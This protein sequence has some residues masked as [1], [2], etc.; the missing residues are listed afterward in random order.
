M[1]RSLVQALICAGTLALASPAYAAEPLLSGEELRRT[2]AG[3]TIVLDTPVGGIPIVYQANGALTGTAKG[4]PAHLMDGPSQ[5]HGRWWIAAGT[6]CQQW[7]AWMEGRQH[8]YQMRIRGKSVHWRR[9]DG[10]T[11]T[12]RIVSN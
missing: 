8:C 3:R 4:M 2:V 12:A 5:D 6:V 11:G 1:Q 10:R 9:E 7:S